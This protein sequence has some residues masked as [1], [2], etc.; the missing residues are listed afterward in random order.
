MLFDA[1]KCA[2]PH[3][4]LGQSLTLKAEDIR[5]HNPKS[6]VP[7]LRFRTVGRVTVLFRTES[8][9]GVSV[10]E[11][12]DMTGKR[13]LDLAVYEYKS[14]REVWDELR[15]TDRIEEATKFYKFHNEWDLV[16]KII[17]LLS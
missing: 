5:V 1:S 4:T 13:V 2:I 9:V 6:D 15:N 14:A 3:D 7:K 8:E 11:Y 10:M 17:E 16:Q 12:T